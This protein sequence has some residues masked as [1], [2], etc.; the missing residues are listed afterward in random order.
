M[1]RYTMAQFEAGERLKAHKKV[2]QGLDPTKPL[3][4][5]S[6]CVLD[7]ELTGLRRRHEIISIGAVRIE[8]LALKPLDRFYTEVCPKAW[9]K[10]GTLIHR[11]SPQQ[12]QD[13]PTIGEVLPGLIAYLG[14]SLLIG[15][16]IALDLQFLQKACKKH[17]GHPLVHPCID[18]LRLARVYEE[19]RWE[20]YY[21]RFT[22][23]VSYQLQELAQAYGLP[24]F[25]AHN[26]AS[27]A[28]QTA[29]LFVYLVHKLRE[30]HPL[31]T[32]ED[33][34]RCGRGWRWYF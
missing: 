13:A 14:T 22:L 18:T 17:L 8:H 4:E 29:Y 20:S 12:C 23:R 15:H 1:K 26:A 27:D 34:Y 32:L 25:P 33:L 19:S 5:F 7:T 6:F 24:C 2:F 28:L 3:S 31:V 21:D 10:T 30:T 16:N 11:I 9:T